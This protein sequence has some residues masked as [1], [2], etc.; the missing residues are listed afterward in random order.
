MLNIREKQNEDYLS[1]HHGV[2]PDEVDILEGNASIIEGENVHYN[3]L[4]DYIDTH[5]LSDPEHYDH[6]R[7]QMDID[8]YIDYQIAEIYFANTDWP[9]NNIK[10]WR[11]RT[12]TGKWRWM[13]FDTDFGFGY[14][15]N[16]QVNS[17]TLA[18][19]TDPSGPGWPNPPWS[20]SC[21]LYKSP[22]PRDRQKASLPSSA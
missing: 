4:L 22:S 11:Q 8:N 9:G 12:D 3:D 16:A 20:T 15:S 5:S 2:D 6:V 10:Y 13:V 17:N 1:D 21:L 14:F 18:M 7:T 19:A